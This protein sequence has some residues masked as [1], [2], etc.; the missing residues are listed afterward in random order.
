[1]FVAYIDYMFSIVSVVLC[2]CSCS[3]SAHPDDRAVG[4]RYCVSMVLIRCLSV[5]APYIVGHLVDR[6]GI[7]SSIV[8]SSN[9]G[10]SKA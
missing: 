9:I 4:G 2:L 3:Y 7:E 8:Y 10:L 6:E 1:M 5:N